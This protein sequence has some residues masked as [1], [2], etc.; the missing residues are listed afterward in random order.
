MGRR[1]TMKISL[2]VQVLQSVALAPVKMLKSRAAR[3]T[4]RRL[5][6]ERGNEREKRERER[7]KKHIL[8]GRS[9][10]KLGALSVLPHCQLASHVI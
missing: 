5:V 9:E 7:A 2:K 6:S 8:D 4:S 3:K 10:V 1:P